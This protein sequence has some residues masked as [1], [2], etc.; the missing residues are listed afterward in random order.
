MKDIDE[1]MEYIRNKSNKNTEDDYNRI[2]RILKASEHVKPNISQFEKANIRAN[3]MAKIETVSVKRHRIKSFVKWSV[4]GSV[5]VI[6]L[7]MSIFYYREKSPKEDAYYSYIVNSTVEEY[8][9]SEINGSE[10]SVSDEDLINYLKNNP[11]II[12]YYKSL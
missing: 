9:Y 2:E 7:F 5:A 12:D 3:I 1:I 4:I 6:A 11:D 8:F 10:E